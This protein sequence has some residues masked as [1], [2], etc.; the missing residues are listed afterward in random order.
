MNQILNVA[1]QV[2][3]WILLGRGSWRCD[4]FGEG[5]MRL[6]GWELV[7]VVV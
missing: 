6:G 4:W 3:H 2:S 1:T 7:V 5:A